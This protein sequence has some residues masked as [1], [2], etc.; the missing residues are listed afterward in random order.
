MEAQCSFATRLSLEG[1]E[2]E[3]R[4]VDVKCGQLV[5]AGELGGRRVHHG[6]NVATHGGSRARARRGEEGGWERTVV[7]LVRLVLLVWLASSVPTLS[8]N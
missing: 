7:N 4:L 5:E 6:R 1:A 2:V 8:G 3:G